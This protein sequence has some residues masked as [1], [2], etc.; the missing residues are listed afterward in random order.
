M[1]GYFY[2][3]DLIFYTTAGVRVSGSYSA[4]NHT[5]GRGLRLPPPQNKNSNYN[6]I[7][8]LSHPQT[9]IGLFIAI[10]MLTPIPSP[11]ALR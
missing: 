8:F 2:A 4:D 3:E 5:L 9:P 6:N 10:A 7:L 1:V 11:F